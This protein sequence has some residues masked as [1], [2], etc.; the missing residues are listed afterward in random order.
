MGELLLTDDD[1]RKIEASYEERHAAFER[2]LREAVEAFWREIK[3]PRADADKR[4]AEP[5]V[6][7]SA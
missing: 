4:P 7:K 6:A 1:R 2:E 5:P 3:A